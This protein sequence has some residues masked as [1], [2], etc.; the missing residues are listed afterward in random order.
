MNVN[1][2]SNIADIAARHNELSG[3]GA[4]PKSL[5][6]RGKAKLLEQIKSMEDAKAAAAAIELG[7]APEAV[8]EAKEQPNGLTMLLKQMQDAKE[9]KVSAKPKAEPKPKKEKKE[10]GPVIR[11][12]AEALLLEVTHKDEDGRPYGHAY[13]TI[14]ERIR[15]QFDGAKT[16]VAC[17]RWYAVHMR[18]RGE[19][20]PNRPRA[21]PA[22]AAKED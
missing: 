18:E 17:L 1:E 7:A 13:D 4:D 16:T 3:K 6:K 19:K 12:V 15:E 14:L 10:K 11:V 2:Q 22:K 20:V 5:A 21:Q 8:E 9:K